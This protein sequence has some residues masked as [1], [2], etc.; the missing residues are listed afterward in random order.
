M[1]LSIGGFTMRTVQYLCASFLCLMLVHSAMGQIP[2]TISYQG[3]LT[4]SAG[5][6]RPDGTYS[7]TFRLYQ[8]SSGGSALW[9]E[10][11]TLQT[12]RGLFST[13]LGDQ[14]TFPGSLAFDRQYWL[15]IQ[16]A[17]N[18][19]M[20]PRVALTAAGYSIRA[21]K[22]DTAQYALGAPLQSAVD[23]ARIA[24]TV[25]NNAITSQKIADSTITGVDINRNTALNITSLRT[26][27]NVGIGT[28]NPTRII[29]TQTP[30]DNY[31]Y[32]QTNGTIELA[33][34]LNSSFSSGMI[35]TVSNHPFQIY[36]SNSGP[37]MTL[38]TGG[39]GGNVGIGTANP[40]GKL[41]VSVPS[42]GTLAFRLLS[43]PNGF[44]DITPTASSNTVISTVNSRNLILDP[45]T[46]NIGIGT[47]TPSARI[48]AT[49]SSNTT[50]TGRF[51]KG[52]TTPTTTFA[53]VHVENFTI[54]GEAA[55]MR[56]ASSS[57]TAPVLTLTRHPSS[58]NNFIDGVNWDG[59][60]PSVRRFHIDANG[61][62]T[63]GS[64]F[65]EA[66]EAS[67]GKALYEPGDV[68]VLSENN[69]KAIEKSNIPY[70]T[71]VAGIYSTRPGVLGADKDGVTRMD[72]NDIPVAIVGIVPTKVTDENGPIQSGD[73]LTTSSLPGHAMK[74]S[75]IVINGIKIYP[76]GA[77]VGKALD[78]LASG[79]GIIKVLVTIK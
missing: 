41:E 27:G 21:I 53:A 30:L 64:D 77:L 73:L 62:Y 59:T 56:T 42:E 24:G 11:K 34:F 23:S 67:G 71:R 28:T 15:G 6:P 22:S 74:A 69:P 4:D 45:G 52:G 75:P 46:A 72:E 55:W 58:T 10:Q 14:V 2:K 50:P 63:T 54:A 44:L 51:R 79:Q 18:P 49:S 78:Q 57:N 9:I 48:D 66:F 5:T 47:T 25:P 70:D 38:T 29:Q 7:F 35:G 32:S 19:E 3:V 61:T 65:A 31:S 16:V 43:G 40:S 39:V 13:N 33:T 68:V 17:A 12:Q 76:T 8:S 26:T 36:T 37:V 1:P 60:N 20:S